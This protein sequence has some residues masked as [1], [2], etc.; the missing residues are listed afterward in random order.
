MLTCNV[1]PT[2]SVTRWLF[3]R[4]SCED[5]CPLRPRTESS[6]FML[7][8][9]QEFAERSLA[10]K[11]DAGKNSEPSTIALQRFDAPKIR[12]RL[13]Q[14][15]AQ[16]PPVEALAAAINHNRGDGF[17]GGQIGDGHFLLDSHRTRRYKQAAV[18]IHHARMRL[19]LIHAVHGLLAPFNR[20]RHSRIHARASAL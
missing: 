1:T 13:H 2:R 11:L 7:L 14:F 20:H 15:H 9:L 6:E 5:T 10:R 18:K 19:V 16:F 3:L 17:V 4:S 12:F 8:D